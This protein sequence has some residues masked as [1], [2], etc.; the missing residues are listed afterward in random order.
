M[1]RQAIEGTAARVPRK[2]RSDP[3]LVSRIPRSA[4]RFRLALPSGRLHKRNAATAVRNQAGTDLLLIQEFVYCPFAS[5]THAIVIDDDV[6]SRRDAVVE[7]V[8]TA[9]RRLIPVAIDAQQ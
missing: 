1:R 6:A 2:T 9:F 7:T 8:Q 4:P 5:K 3:R